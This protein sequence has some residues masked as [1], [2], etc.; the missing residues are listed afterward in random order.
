MDFEH[1]LRFSGANGRSNAQVNHATMTFIV[2]LCLGGI[3]SVGRELFAVRAQIGGGKPD[4]LSQT[5]A[6]SHR[7]ENRVFATEHFDGGPEITLLTCLPD[8]RAA[9]DCDIYFN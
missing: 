2:D 6:A 3:N 8:R 1:A 7:S 9:H 4:L 5:V